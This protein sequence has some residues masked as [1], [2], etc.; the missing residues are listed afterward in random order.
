MNIFLNLYILVFITGIFTYFVKKYPKRKNSKV[1]KIFL[2]IGIIFFVLYLVEL[3]KI[4]DFTGAYSQNICYGISLSSFILS[5]KFGIKNIFLKIS[6]FI[7]FIINI[8]FIHQI[9]FTLMSSLLGLNLYEIPDIIK[10]QKDYRIESNTNAYGMSTNENIFFVWKHIPF[11]EKIKITTIPNHKY[12]DSINFSEI[13]N[14]M[15]IKYNGNEVKLDTI[16]NVK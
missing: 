11:D 15:R 8:P 16:I 14:E 12:I 6:N 4:S 7:F 1:S 2:T 10:N 13:Q 5:M 3:F 9:I